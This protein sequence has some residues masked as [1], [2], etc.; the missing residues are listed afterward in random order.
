MGGTSDEHAGKNEYN[1]VNM[2]REL[3]NM[4]RIVAQY[5]LQNTKIRRKGITMESEKSLQTNRK[6]MTPKTIIE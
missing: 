1:R 4:R 3:I 2:A 5:T 6:S